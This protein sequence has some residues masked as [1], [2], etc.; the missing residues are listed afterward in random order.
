M[1]TVGNVI[2]NAGHSDSKGVE[3]TVTARPLGNFLLTANY[4]YTYARFLDYKKN[5][6]TNYAGKMIPL[7]PRHTLDV[8]AQYTIRPGRGFDAIRLSTNVTGVGKLYWNEDNAQAQRFYALLNAK[9]AFQKGIVTVELWGKNLTGTEYLSYYFV[10]SA[11]YAQK[12][13]PL[14]FG[15]N[16]ILDL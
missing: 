16:V 3:M 13:K 14:T 5:E 10:S 2:D 15:A 6:T 1:P 8:G 12:G 9:A 7:V 4:G 11:A